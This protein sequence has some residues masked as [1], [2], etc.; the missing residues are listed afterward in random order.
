MSPTEKSFS[1]NLLTKIT[2][3]FLTLQLP[4]K[5]NVYDLESRVETRRP[6][7]FTE[8]YHHPGATLGP[9]PRSA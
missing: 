3:N 9:M 6:E 4:A 7:E 1:L 5:A 8:R 2:K